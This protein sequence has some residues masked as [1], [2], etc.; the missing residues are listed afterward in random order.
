MSDTVYRRLAWATAVLAIALLI[1]SAVMLFSVPDPANTS[2]L[3]NQITAVATLG[4]PILGLV[5]VTKQPRHRIGWLWIL[6]GLAVSLRTFGYA[7]YY[8][9]GARPTGY[10][11]LAYFLLWSTELVNVASLIFPSLLMLWFPDGQLLSRRWRFLY[12]WLFLASAVLSLGLFQPGI[13]WNG[14]ETAGGIVIDNPYGWLPLDALSLLIPL[15]FFSLVTIMILAAASLVLRYRSG[16]QIMRLQLRWFVVGGFSYV[17]LNFLPTFFIG[18]TEV[19]TGVNLLMY[20]LSFSAIVLLYLAVGVAILRYRLYDIDVIIRRTL[21]YGVLS[22]LLALTYFGMVI[23]L[24]GLFESFTDEQSPIAIVV[25]TL[26]IAGLFTP[27]RR[28]VQAA[29]DRRFYRGKY[30]AGQ[31]LD[32]FAQTARD[33]VELD[34]LTAELLQVVQETVQPERVT[35]WLKT[36]DFDRKNS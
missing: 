35:V 21:Q 13:N 3:W 5:I 20:T 26:L 15:A 7:I 32:R 4:A 28:R 12:I 29:I 27:M 2:W 6:W 33:E 8:S 19:E 1:I 30:D 11:T 34:R 31:A 23:L 10:S 36:S 18:E 17:V 22:G 24:Q 16:G 9:A 14:G 25:S